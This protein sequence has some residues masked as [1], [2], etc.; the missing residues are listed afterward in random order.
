MWKKPFC[1]FFFKKWQ[2]P[3]KSSFPVWC[4]DGFVRQI[5]WRDRSRPP[6]NGR[7]QTITVL[8]KVLFVPRARRREA[9][10]D[11]KFKVAPRSAGIAFIFFTR[12]VNNKSSTCTSGGGGDKAAQAW[13]HRSEN[14]GDRMVIGKEK[15][16]KNLANSHFLSSTQPAGNQKCE[17]PLC[18][19]F[20]GCAHTWLGLTLPISG[21][22]TQAQTSGWLFVY[23]GI[24][25]NHY[26]TMEWGKK[27]SKRN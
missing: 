10:T 3:N 4:L 27:P 5:L 12:G 25:C 13:C 26:S 11:K 24:V 8:V 19:F 6:T 22:G 15:K 18:S 21:K 14:G 7:Q 2:R 9:S 16:K 17:L 20:T 23:F 1:S